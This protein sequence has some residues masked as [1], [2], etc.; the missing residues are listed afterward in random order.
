[1]IAFGALTRMKSAA[2]AALGE[3]RD[4]TAVEP[5]SAALRDADPRVRRAAEDA[6]SRIDPSWRKRPAAQ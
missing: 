3:M 4:Q 1:M 6:L 2:A 5:L